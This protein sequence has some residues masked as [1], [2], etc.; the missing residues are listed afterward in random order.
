MQQ[1][2]YW[3]L[4]IPKNDWNRPEHIYP[5]L[6]CLRGQLERGNN[7]DYEHWQLLATFK[8][9]VRLSAVKK[10]FGTTC[11]AEPSR[12]SA[13]DAYV[14]KDDT[15]IEGSRF[16]L[17]AKPFKRNS[18]S[19]W[20]SIWEAA[21]KGKFD[22]IPAN[23]RVNSY[24]AICRIAK[25]NLKPSPMERKCYV[26]WGKTGTGKS[27]RAW[28]E[29]GW[30]AYPK[31]PSTKF[32][33]GYQEHE[34]VVIDEFTGQIGIEHLLRWCDR[35]PVSV[36]TKGSATVFSAK[37]IWFT[38]N[39]DPR[40]WY[41]NAPIEQQEALLRRL[42]ITHFEENTVFADAERIFFNNPELSNE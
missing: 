35:Y 27:R 8:R 14:H 38:S 33:D 4:T 9:A 13:A 34:N 3:I 12:S 42:E 29:A 36:E 39:I 23:I 2:R 41:P 32:W 19:D 22:D 15:A 25:D 16:E 30:D 17:G 21:K 40:K 1:A 18:A 11:H 6:A 28:E 5:E 26:F 7:T 24:N 31:I 10:I 20:D 37:K